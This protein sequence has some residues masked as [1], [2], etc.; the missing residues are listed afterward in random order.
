MPAAR[1]STAT[2]NVIG[3]DKSGV[4]AKITNFLYRQGGNI[5]ELD[6]HVT[7]GLFTMQMEIS[8][9]TAK[10]HEDKVRTGLQRLAKQLDMTILLRSHKGGKRKPRLGVLVT[11]ETHCLDQLVADC[12]SGK[13]PATIALVAANKDDIKEH[14]T[15]RHKLPFIHID[16]RDKAKHEATILSQFDKAEIDYV[17]LARYMR[18]LSPNFVWRY[19]N[20]IINIHPSLLP[21]FPGASAYRQAHHKGVRVAGV[22]AHVVTMHLDEGPIVSQKAFNVSPNDS[23]ADIRRKGQRHEGNVLSQAV[24]LL[25]ENKLDI[26]WGKTTVRQST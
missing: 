14:V 16:D 15:Q 13:I 24:K 7:Q 6:Q 3:K 23:A 19:P 25:V 11:K 17:V 4:I 18:I 2:V 8:W 12:K 1:R 22:T 5:E 26:H 20:R 9:P 10:L 21:S